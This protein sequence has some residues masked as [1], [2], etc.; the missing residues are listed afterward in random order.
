MT[1]ELAR[2]LVVEDSDIFYSVVVRSLPRFG[3]IR[4]ELRRARSLGEALEI[5]AGGS[6]SP[7]DVILL[8]LGLPDS[9]GS[10]TVRAVHEAAPAIPI[11]V[12]TAEPSSLVE[13]ACI[14]EGAHDYIDKT[15]VTPIGLERALS[16]A[17][18]R[19]RQAAIDERHRLLE[20]YRAMLA[21]QTTNASGPA[22]AADGSLRKRIPQSLGEID[23][24]YASLF[25]DYA[26]FA[27]G[28]AE[29]PAGEM[30]AIGERLFELEAGPKDLLGIH[31]KA[32]ESTTRG[33]DSESGRAYAGAARSLI[34]E[35][36]SY[37]IMRYR[38]RAV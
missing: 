12:L 6:A 27:A 36:M 24:R 23:Y 26:V 18:A 22:P 20:R 8:D 2:L 9:G 13:N 37:L 11:V 1:N 10:D 17:L 5:L 3:A 4:A 28:R 14:A 19:K 29:R 30:R 21:G 31:V 16:F 33:A 7:V 32:L 25:E 34:L 38:A 15:E 35:M